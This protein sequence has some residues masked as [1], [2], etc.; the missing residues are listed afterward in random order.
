MLLSYW[1]D[2]SER[3]WYEI[4]PTCMPD[5]CGFAVS[6]LNPCYIRIL[7]PPH[8]R[9]ERRSSKR[10]NAGANTESLIG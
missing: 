4:L 5:T 6:T 7:I 10:G 8:C 3:E 2:H 1:F 9:I